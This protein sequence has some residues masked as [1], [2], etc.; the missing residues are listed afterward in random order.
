MS[1]EG[2]ILGR[3]RLIRELGR[4][5]MGQVWLAQ[6]RED[7][8]PEGFPEQAAIKILPA[9]LTQEPGIVL[10]FQREMEILGK[11]SEILH[12]DEID[13]VI[14]NTAS[15]PLLARIIKNKKI[16]TDKDPFLRHK[17]ESL[18]LRKYFRQGYVFR[19]SP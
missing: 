9:S 13:L 7:T 17:F 2:R 5:G 10:R 12:T 4:G 8:P 18:T 1:A 16:L 6:H 11:L 14:L 19:L 3:W 15:L